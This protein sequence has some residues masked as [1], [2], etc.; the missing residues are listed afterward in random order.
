MQRRSLIGKYEV[1]EELGRGNITVVYRAKQVSLGRIVALRVLDPK[2]S[3]DPEFVEKFRSEARVSAKLNHPNIAQVYDIGGEDGIHYVASE[4]CEGENLRGLIRKKKKL[5]PEKVGDILTQIARALDYVHQENVFHGFIKPTDVIVTPEGR[6]KLVDLGMAR[7]PASISVAKLSV[8]SAQYMSPEQVQRKEIGPAAD[9]YSL[10]VLVYE[11]LTGR[12]PFLSDDPADLSRKILSEKPVPLQKWDTGIR[13][14]IQSIVLKCLEKTPEKRYHAAGEIVKEWQKA[15][16][17]GVEKAT[18]VTRMFKG[19]DTIIRSRKS[20]VPARKK[21]RLRLAL[22]AAIL[23]VAAPFLFLVQ[24]SSLSV[25]S[26]PSG[27]SIYVDEKYYGKTP[28]LVKGLSRG[29]HVVTG[30]KEGFKNFRQQVVLGIGEAS[31]RISLISRT[32][33]ARIITAPEGA[34]VYVDGVLKGRTPLLLKEM[35]PGE[36]KIKLMLDDYATERR[37]L[38][39]DGTG[40]LTLEAKLVS[41]H[42]SLIINSSPSEAEVYVDDVYKGLTPKT[43]A[44]LKSGPYEI[45]IKKDGYCDLKRKIFLREQRD[46]TLRAELEEKFVFLIVRSE[47]AGARVSLDGR[48]VGKAP[49]SVGKLRPREYKIKMEKKGY[50]VVEKTVTLGADRERVSVDIEM[51]K[52]TGS[53]LVICSPSGGRVYVDGEEKGAINV[54]LSV[55]D[56]VEGEHQLQ[57]VKSGYKVIDQKFMVTSGK[58]IVVNMNLEEIVTKWKPTVRI[59]LRT[60]GAIEGEIVGREADSIVLRV[61]AGLITLKVSDV[62]SEESLEK[63]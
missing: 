55:K 26:E 40:P 36:Y 12:L 57:V 63:E 25:E 10:G 46:F 39:V 27:V 8:A 34:G 38:K 4:Y 7:L 21:R 14:E 50:A 5:S 56:L 11:M 43:L 45:L 51:R 53:L 62:K 31:L 41:L 15:S 17:V 49:L 20:L 1:I 60:G 37:V 16:K 61:E 28:V 32:A 48:Y 33:L 9:V 42:G 24:R 44:K 19:G 52:I 58:T 6:V 2:F 29:N 13:P 30:R 18:L 35:R 23:L 3:S 59:R 47:P 22:V 54:S